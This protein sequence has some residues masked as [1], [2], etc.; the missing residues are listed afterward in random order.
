LAISALQLA[1]V[2]GIAAI[3]LAVFGFGFAAGLAADIAKLL[4]LLVVI[5]FLVSVCSYAF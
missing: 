3:I 4:L 2:F 1:I 5:V